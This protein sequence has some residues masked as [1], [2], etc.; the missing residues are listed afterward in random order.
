MVIT[1]ITPNIDSHL[2][3]EVEDE[4][5]KVHKC[6]VLLFVAMADHN[7]GQSTIAPV[8]LVEGKLSI[9]GKR[10]IRHED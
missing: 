10:L 8:A 9:G 7:S 6:L 1:A 5:R 4:N 2:F 3:V